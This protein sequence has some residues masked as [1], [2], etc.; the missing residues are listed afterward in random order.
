MNKTEFVYDGEMVEAACEKN[1]HVLTATV[2]ETVYEFTPVGDNLYATTVDGRRC[3]VAVAARNGTYFVDIDSMLIELQEPSEDG[4]AGGA[5][6]QAGEKDKIFAP[7]PGKIVKI[8]VEVGDDVTE[9]QPMVIVEAMKMEN[10]VNSRAVGKVK[11]VNFAVGDQV[12]TESPIIEL[13][14]GE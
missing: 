5:G 12:D 1:G 4:F 3:L 7:M 8:M 6:S 11:A 9:K 2:G 13:E 10:Q 14:L